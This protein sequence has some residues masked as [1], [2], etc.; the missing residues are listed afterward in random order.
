MRDLIISRRSGQPRDLRTQLPAGPGTEKTATGLCD[1][2]SSRT[3]WLGRIHRDLRE[4]GP[5][6]AGTRSVEDGEAV[7]VERS[8]GA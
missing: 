2:G 5:R 4:R 1:A 7:E 3:V 8:L 6:M